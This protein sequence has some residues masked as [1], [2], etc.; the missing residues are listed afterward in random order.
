MCEVDD[1]CPSGYDCGGVIYDCTDSPNSCPSDSVCKQFTIEN[2]PEPKRLCSDP[3]TGWP[4]Q[5]E[6][7]CAPRS[8]NCPPQ[9]G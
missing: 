8:G 6:K 4:K 7:C 9:D 1:D 5:F 3:R 2:E